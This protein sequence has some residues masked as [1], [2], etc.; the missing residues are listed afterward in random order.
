[1][2]KKPELDPQFK[3]IKEKANKFIAKGK[4]EQALETYLQLWKMSPKD[5]RIRL[6]IG[7]I[8]Q[9]LNR[10][11]EALAV[12]KKVAEAYAKEGFLIQAIS[13]CKIILEKEPQET[14]IK[15]LLA[16]LYAKRGMLKDSAKVSASVSPVRTK[17]ISTTSDELLDEFFAED[18]E[19]GHGQLPEIPL[20]SD[21]ENNAFQA[22]IDSLTPWRVPEG[23]VICQEG[24]Q[25]DSMF[26]IANGSIRVVTKDPKGKEIALA[27]LNPGDFFGEIG[28]FTSSPRTASCV[29]ADETDLLE[30]KRKSFDQI[31]KKFPSVKKV[32]HDFYKERIFDTILAK[33]E[34]FG[35]FNPEIRKALMERF[36][37]RIYEPQDP[38]V[39][40]GEKGNCM[41]MIRDGQVEVFTQDD[42]DKE[43][44]LATLGPGE[45]FGEVA[46]LSNTKRTASIRA[47]ER[48]DILQLNRKDF[49]WA[50]K[51]SPE[52]LKVIQEYV[53]KRVK[54][55]IEAV[56]QA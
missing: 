17:E 13:V 35:C 26:I 56:T 25:A 15:T 38:I 45:F 31:V 27:N 42:E 48:C 19:V 37:S 34:L 51:Q 43:I 3:K 2:V 41:Y 28:L 16:S 33:S 12:Y 14:Q 47:D 30:I 21:L 9:K 55:T 44:P 6:K 32:L 7:D 5:F 8:L 49:D 40:E 24:S 39:Q 52:A 29:A 11:K 1:M 4:W 46:L 36:E 53:Q 10:L 18:V 50:M 22:V 20:F 54:G 23:T